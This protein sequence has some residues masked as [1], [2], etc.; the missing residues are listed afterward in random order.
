VSAADAAERIMI[1]RAAAYAQWAAE[2]D[3]TARTAAA[4]AGFNLS[5]DAQVVAMHGEL[6]LA[7]HAKRAEALRRAHFTNMARKSAAARRARK[8]S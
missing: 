4:R 6:P 8:K 7:E 5:F 3:W 1:A 2:P